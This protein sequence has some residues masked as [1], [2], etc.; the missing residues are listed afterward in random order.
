MVQKALNRLELI[1]R[2]AGLRLLDYRLGKH[3]FNLPAATELQPIT[4]VELILASDVKGFVGAADSRTNLAEFGNPF[5]LR[6][7]RVVDFCFVLF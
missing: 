7:R 6:T 2:I 3:V 1:H 5:K 4:Q